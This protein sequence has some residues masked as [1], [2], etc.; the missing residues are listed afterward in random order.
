MDSKNDDDYEVPRHLRTNKRKFGEKT[1]MRNRLGRAPSPS[2]DRSQS[3][4][5]PRTIFDLTSTEADSNEDV[6]RDIANKL[7]ETKEDLISMILMLKTRT[8]QRNV[9]IFIS[10]VFQRAL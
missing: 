8:N 6:S 5:Q 2:D 3:P 7:S 1:S 9:S 4:S 10:Y